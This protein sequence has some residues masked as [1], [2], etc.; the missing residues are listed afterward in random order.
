MRKATE[1]ILPATQNTRELALRFLR[2]YEQTLLLEKINIPTDSPA[3]EASITQLMKDGSALISLVP[4]LGH[5]WIG[6]SEDLEPFARMIVEV[7]EVA[8]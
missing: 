4:G 1:D 6:T 7:T 2:T 5:D 3:Y 8:A